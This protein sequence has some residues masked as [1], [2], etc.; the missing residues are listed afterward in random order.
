[1]P[2][3]VK[4]PPPASNGFA[5]LIGSLVLV[6]VHSFEPQAVT[7]FGVKDQ[8]QITIFVVDHPTNPSMNGQ[9]I[10]TPVTNVILVGQLRSQ[11]G[12]TVL[13]RVAYGKQTNA[14]PPVKLDDPTPADEAMADQY[15]AANPPGAR[16]AAAPPVQQPYQPAP[17]TYQPQ[18]QF[19]P[20][21]G[22]PQ[23]SPVQPVGAP[24]GPYPGQTPG[25][26]PNGAQPVT[27]PPYAQPGQSTAPPF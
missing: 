11:V 8:C 3:Y 17:P 16:T 21:P 5:P 18:Q 14:N 24:A 1:M 6:E 26:P 27:Q 7:P 20:P 15:L 22:Y 23:G 9:V 25:Q 13:G 2:G 12:Q 10:G 4:A 19:A